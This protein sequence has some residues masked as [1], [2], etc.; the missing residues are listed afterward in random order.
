MLT[1][2]LARRLQADGGTVRTGCAVTS[3]DI[4]QGRVRGVVLSDGEHVPATRVVSGAHVRTTLLDLVTADHLPPSLREEVAA[5][6]VGN[7]FGM[8]VRCAAEE[9]PHYRGVPTEVPADMHMGL[10]LLA[11][12]AETMRRAHAEFLLGRSSFEPQVIAMTFSAFDPDLAPPGRHVV[13]LWSQYHPYQLASGETWDTIREREADRICEQ[14]YRFAP[15]MRGKILH[16]HIQSPL[17]LER[18]FGLL[19][20]NV[21]H[22]EMSLDQMFSF[23]PTPSLSRYRTPV[24]GLYLTGASTHPGGGVFGASGYSA[25]RVMLRDG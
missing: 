3:I 15:N 7:G 21:M 2:A 13:Y 11:G 4:T 17:D 19:R 5:A 25:A 12:S 1:Q 24:G 18:R 22:L 8:A 9:L 10:Q 16:R 23:R 6:R 20:G 14:L